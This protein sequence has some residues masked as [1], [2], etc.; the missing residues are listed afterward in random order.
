M[1]TSLILRLMT[2]SVKIQLVTL[3]LGKINTIFIFQFN[4]ENTSVR[5]AVPAEKTI[6]FLIYQYKQLVSFRICHVSFSVSHVTRQVTKQRPC[7][8]LRAHLL[9]QRVLPPPFPHHALPNNNKN[10]NINNGLSLFLPSFRPLFWTKFLGT[11]NISFLSQESKCL[12]F[13][14]EGYL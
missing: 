8:T 6:F 7:R 2:Q 14:R 12:Y 3:L 10:N 13:S 9:I 4:K 11:Q 1:P 5:L